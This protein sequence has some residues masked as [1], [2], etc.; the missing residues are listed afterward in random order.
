MSTQIR[1]TRE[2]YSLMD[3]DW[4]AECLSLQPDRSVRF[5]RFSTSWE[6]LCVLYLTSHIESQF[7]KTDQI[8]RTVAQKAYAANY[9]GEWE[10]VQVILERYPRTPKEFY[11]IFL[12]FHSSEEFFGNLVPR[13]RRLSRGIGSKKRDPHGPVRRA[14]RHRGYKDK[15]T[16]RPPHQPAVVPPSS[17]SK[18]DRRKKIQHPLLRESGEENFAGEDHCPNILIQKGD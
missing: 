13:S 14:Q 9:E 6:A 11:D 5:P 18:T 12:E 17:D 7:W 16:L 1:L 10:V 2:D 15:G 3:D 4:I 8:H